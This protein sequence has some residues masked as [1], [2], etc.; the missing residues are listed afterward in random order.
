VH[1]TADRTNKVSHKEYRMTTKACCGGG[2]S[3]RKRA[4]PRGGKLV[5]ASK[6]PHGWAKWL[7]RVAGLPAAVRV[8]KG[9]AA[10]GVGRVIS[11]VIRPYRKTFA[12]PERARPRPPGPMRRPAD[13]AAALEGPVFPM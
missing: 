10:C 4:E 3:R 6:L 5:W 1:R 12:G 2:R 7:S 11:G 13:H 8:P 9:L